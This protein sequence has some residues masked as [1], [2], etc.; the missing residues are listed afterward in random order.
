MPIRDIKLNNK[1]AYFTYGNTNV[2]YSY[3]LN[4]PSS[5]KQ[6]YSKILRYV[7]AIHANKR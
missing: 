4:D 2:M 7:R 6:A 3:Y 1:I 5:K